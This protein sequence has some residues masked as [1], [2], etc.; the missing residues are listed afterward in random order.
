MH[1]PA[2]PDPG[3]GSGRGAAG[4]SLR[5]ECRGV[6]GSC[7]RSS[8]GPAGRCPQERAKAVKY[9]VRIADEDI[10]LEVV[11]SGRFDRRT[12]GDRAMQADLVRIAA[13]PSTR[14]CSTAAPTSS[15][16]TGGTATPNSSLAAR[17][18]RPRHGR[19]RHADR[20]GDGRRRWQLSGE[21]VLAPMPGVVIGVTVAAGDTVEAGQGVITLEAMKMEN[22]LRCARR[23][24]RQRGQGRRSARACPRANLWWS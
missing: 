24:R 14:S 22:E 3:G 1:K 8:A 11:H 10:E 12:L 23:G 6:A 17:L 16:H 18:R 4:S 21:T 13:R 7:T 9:E 2:E 15:P 5:A 20:G 19:A